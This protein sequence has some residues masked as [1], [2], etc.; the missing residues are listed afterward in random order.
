MAPNPIVFVLANPDPEIPYNDAVRVRPDAIVATGRSD[1]PN[2]VNNVLGFPFIF[3]GALDVGATAINDEMKLAA[4]FALAKLALEPVPQVVCD[5]YGGAPIEFGP[6]YI[7]P[8]P[9]DPRVLPWVSTAVAEAA[10]ATGAAQMPVDI[11][12]YRRK[13][14]IKAGL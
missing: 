2:Q 10:V 6:R 13:L 3:R 8:K 1:F 9:F 4:A 7:I 14:E 5:A 12:A 11:A